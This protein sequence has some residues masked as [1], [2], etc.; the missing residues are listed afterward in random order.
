MDFYVCGHRGR[1]VALLLV[2][3]TPCRCDHNPAFPRLPCDYPNR[4][5]LRSARLLPQLLNLLHPAHTLLH[6][7]THPRTHVTHTRFPTHT[8]VVFCHVYTVY[9]HAARAHASHHAHA[10]AHLRSTALP[11]ALP[12]RT[13]HTRLGPHFGSPPPV[14]SAVHPH[15]LYRGEHLAFAVYTCNRIIRTSNAIGMLAD[16]H[17]K[18]QRT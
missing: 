13:R 3:K 15:R 12:P 9:A 4:L 8:H 10:H 1:L 18:K 5:V 6:T 11:H 14:G 16:A 17:R 7:H 2:P